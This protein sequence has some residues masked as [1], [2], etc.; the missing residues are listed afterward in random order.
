MEMA[1]VKNCEVI[2]CSYN[3]DGM[4]HALAITIGDEI[5]PTCDTFCQSSTQGGDQNS[6]AGVGACKVESCAHN[7]CLECD[8]S[9]IMVG[10]NQDEVDCLSFMTC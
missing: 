7:H 6:R 5:H 9:D 10:Y 3:A 8:C 2:E 1:R 4:C